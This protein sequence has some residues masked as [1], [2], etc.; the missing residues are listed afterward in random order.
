MP[1]CH[2]IKSQ[3]AKLLATEDLIV[4]HKKVETAEFNVHTRVLTLPMW[5]KASN[6]VYDSLVAHEV[7]HAL[8]TPDVEPPKDVPH[9]F[10]NITEDVRIEKLMRR[11]YGGIAKTFYNGYH[12]LSDDDFFD[13]ADK[14]IADFNLADRINLYFK[15]GSFVDISFSV[16]EK[17]IVDLVRNSESFDDA[18]NAAKVLYSYC[19][20]EMEDNLKE[21]IAEAESAEVAKVDIKGSGRPDLGEDD[22]EYD[23]EDDGED[24]NKIDVEYQ[25]TQSSSQ[26]QPTIEELQEQLENLEPDVETVESFNNAVKDLVDNDSVENNYVELPKINLDKVIISNALIHHLC[27]RNWEDYKDK[28]PYRYDVTEEELKDMT[29]FTMVDLE[30][31]K[32]KKSAQK[33][34]SYLVKEFECKKAADSYARSTVSKTGVLNTSKLHTYNFNEDL[35]KKINVVPDGKNHGL[36]FIL[37][38][39]GSMADVMEDTIKQLYN[40]IWFCRKVSIPFEVYAFTLNFPNCDQEGKPNCQS[41]YVP[42][43]GVAALEHNFSLM[44][45]FT[46]DVNGKELEKQMLNIFRCAKTFN[47]NNW[48]QYGVPLG[49]NLSG[50]PLNETIVCLH[51]ILPQFKKKHQLQKVQCVI[52]T[53]GEANPIRYHREVQRPWEEDPFLGTNYVG[54]NTFLRDRTTGNVYKFTDNWRESTSILL[55]NLKDKFTDMNFVGIRLLSPRDGNYFIRQ[56]C[57]YSGKDY[58]RATKDW[59][60]TKSFSIKSSGYDSYFG[61]SASALS[62]DDEFEVE[63]DATKA[64]IKRAFFKSLKG[65]KMN[66]KILGEFVDLV[67]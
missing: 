40:L 34:V 46:S 12:E 13:V 30:Y 61:L 3:L 59:K 27:H 60:K 25:T 49:M 42:K 7:G 64:Q 36:V 50:T 39:S 17:E 19:Q 58:E 65:K 6:N 31:A 4:E 33:E 67:V 38:W 5:E 16:S 66:K 29:V 32:F 22:S 41:S 28:T 15:I 23:E 51:Q 44:N 35:F 20:N 21:Q 18:V 55:R 37:D 9:T 45:L 8:Y 47:R 62:S 52:L 11:R 14:N 43:S 1:V 10:I 57:G 53:D 56:Y 2:E 26:V 54:W 63:S 24:A 48:T